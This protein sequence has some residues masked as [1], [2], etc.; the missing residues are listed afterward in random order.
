[1]KDL[2]D[3]LLEKYGPRLTTKDMEA[4]LKTS[5]QNIRKDICKGK[6]PIPTFKAKKGRR[7]PRY[8]DYRVVAEYINA[9][10]GQ[11]SQDQ[12]VYIAP[13]SASPSSR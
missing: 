13:K 11:V 5:A 1:M 6:F 8:A 3:F 9:S 10:S 4:V 7:A 2:A 12:D